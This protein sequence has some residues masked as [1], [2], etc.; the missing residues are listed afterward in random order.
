MSKPPSEKNAPDP[1]DD[2]DLGRANIV[3]VVFIIVLFAAGFWLFK[4]LQQNNDVQ[5]CIALGRRDC[6][7][8]TRPDGKT[9]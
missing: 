6:I 2:D 8:L 7:D 4:A 1:S 9:P 3:A 5:N